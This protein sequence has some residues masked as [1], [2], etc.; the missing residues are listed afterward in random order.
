MD[1]IFKIIIPIAILLIAGSI[2]YYYVI[3]LPQK[4]EALKQCILKAEDSYSNCLRHI[5]ALIDQG[6]LKTL[7]N[8]DQLEKDCLEYFE[9]AKDTCV[10]KYPVR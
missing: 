7:E 5:Q 9:T 6:V 4:E 1:K 8:F 10:K 3:F 2:F